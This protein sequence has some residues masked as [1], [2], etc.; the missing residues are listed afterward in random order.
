MFNTRVNYGVS[1]LCPFF[2]EVS[3]SLR[4]YFGSFVVDSRIDRGMR[5][6]Y[7]GN[8]NDSWSNLYEH[9]HASLRVEL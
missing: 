8:V 3:I 7:N 2:P 9:H 4:H 5:Y 1:V 6:P